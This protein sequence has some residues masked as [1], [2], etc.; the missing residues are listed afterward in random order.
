MTNIPSMTLFEGR[1][2]L[3]HYIIN[4]ARRLAPNA[5]TFHFGQTLAQLDLD[6]RTASFQSTAVTSSSSTLRGS[7]ASGSKYAQNGSG[8]C[9]CCTNSLQYDLLVGAD[10]FNS[11]VRT[12]LTQQVLPGKVLR[13]GICIKRR[14]PHA[15]PLLSQLQRRC[16]L[17][18][19]LL[20]LDVSLSLQPC[21]QVPGFTAH[22]EDIDTLYKC[23]HR[24]PNDDRTAPVTVF[25]RSQTF[26]TRW[27]SLLVHR[28]RDSHNRSN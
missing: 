25:G 8:S 2:A 14:K 17:L 6:S 10:G 20:L 4:E 18:L 22:V 16:M 21:A 15:N 9:A 1:S 11:R 19:L 13:F 26:F 23:F 28:C 12:S 5:I 7:C 3:Q 24:I 27:V